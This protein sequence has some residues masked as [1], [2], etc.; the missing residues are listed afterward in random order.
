MIKRKLFKDKEEEIIQIKEK[1][2]FYKENEKLIT[3]FSDNFYDKDPID[4]IKS[5]KEKHEGEINLMHEKEDLKSTIKNLEKKMK[6][7]KK[8]FF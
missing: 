3:L 6:K 5:Y 1:L 7:L 4:I 2:Q 8:I